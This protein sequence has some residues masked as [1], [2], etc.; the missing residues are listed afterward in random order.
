[1]IKNDN[2]A[3]KRIDD[4]FENVTIK[5]WNESTDLL[6]TELSLLTNYSENDYVINKLENILQNEE[7][8][9]LEPLVGIKSN[10]TSLYT[11]K[12]YHYARVLELCVEIDSKQ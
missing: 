1:M 6:I 2:S 10:L 7:Q 5:D 4:T 3:L 12:G 9:G 11:Q 8:L